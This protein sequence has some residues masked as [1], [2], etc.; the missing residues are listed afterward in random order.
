MLFSLTTLSKCA[1]PPLACYFLLPLL[2]F[3]LFRDIDYGLNRVSCKR[4]VEFLTPVPQIV[5]LFVNMA[6]ADVAKLK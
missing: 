6:F 4:Y 2:W 5:T 1:S 3:I